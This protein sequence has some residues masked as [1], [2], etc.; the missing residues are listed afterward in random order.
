MEWKI[1]R[2]KGVWSS[3]QHRII[4]KFALGEKKFVP[5]YV[6]MWNSFI[7]SVRLLTHIDMTLTGD[8]EKTAQKV[9]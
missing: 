7:L 3:K 4:G 6:D 9:H 8:W 2:N 1:S 5:D